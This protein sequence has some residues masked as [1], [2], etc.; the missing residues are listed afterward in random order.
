M[1]DFH[2]TEGEVAAVASGAGA[3]ARNA[4]ILTRRPADEQVKATERRSPLQEVV[5]GD[6]AQ[7]NRMREALGQDGRGEF[8][9]LGAPQPLELRAAQLGGADA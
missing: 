2:E 8:L 7:V 1:C 4:E 9:D 3:E 5:S 6:V